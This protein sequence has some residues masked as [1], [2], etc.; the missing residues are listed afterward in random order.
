MT[1]ARVSRKAIR[2][3][4][5]AW[6]LGTAMAI[7]ATMG[8]ASCS[9][10]SHSSA[11][12]G[13]NTGPLDATP[14]DG[15]T[16]DG[17]AGDAM[18]MLP[19]NPD[20][21]ATYVAKVKNLLVGL[22][23][24]PQEVDAVANDPSP[25][26]QLGTLV[27][28]WMGS[29]SPCAP[30]TTT[31]CA[32]LYQTKMLRFFELAF[33][34]TQVIESDFQNQVGSGPG[35]GVSI[36]QN[37]Q[38]LFART[39][40]SFVGSNQ[41]FNTAMTTTKYMMTTSA[42][43]FFALTDAVQDKDSVADVP[44]NDFFTDA[45]PN[46]TVIVESDT[47]IDPA[48]SAT[49]GNKYFMQ[50][51]DPT[52]VVIP[53]PADAGAPVSN[54]KQANRL[55]YSNSSSLRVWYVLN[56]IYFADDGE[57]NGSSKQGGQMQAN[58]YTNWKMVQ[59]NQA[60]TSA[61][62]LTGTTAFYDIASFRNASTASMTLERP[63]VGYFT[64]PAF[65]ANWQTNDS[66]QMRVTA[67]QALIVATG[68]AINPSDPTDA[69]QSPPGLDQDHATQAQCV[70]CHE[71]LD[72][73]R[74]IFS[75]TFSWY[76][77]QQTNYPTTPGAD[78][79]PLLGPDGGPYDWQAEKGR[80]IFEGVSQA[81]SS[82]YDFGTILSTHP[83]LPSAWAQKL[84]YYF[85]SQACVADGSDPVFNA[86]WKAFQSGYSWN[87]LVR[88]VAI[89]PLTTYA[90]KTVTAT[91]NGETVAVSR[92][93]HLC[94]ALDARLGFQDVCRL[95][96]TIYPVIPGAALAIVPGLPS[97][98][99]GRGSAAPILPNQPTLFYR[100][101]TENFCEALAQIVVD[102]KAAPAG[103]KTWQSSDCMAGD[104]SCSTDGGPPSCPPI[105]DFVSLVAGIPSNDP[106]FCPLYEALVQDFVN[107]Q[108]EAGATKTVALQ[109]TFTAACMAPSA[110][111]IGL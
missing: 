6:I 73:T 63:Y 102:Y 95:D 1:L 22:P 19:F 12:G 94:A 87:A 37:Q 96:P 67:N 71:H 8:A 72:P 25:P 101:G 104:G 109:S 105:A 56:G 50:W 21:P 93:D 44:A 54:C 106:R 48:D 49:P 90:T 10:A 92:R 46:Q 76:Y 28:T 64:T 78:G 30:L 84:C 51:Y 111:S 74:S 33:Q 82:I 103:A 57:C 107:N 79:G 29:T 68:A 100:S 110:I 34:Q 15:T 77:G 31:S 36:V 4:R 66:N 23:A 18:A 89:S 85:D 13:P 83:L 40:L 80:F 35:F 61:Q 91:T 24:T 70:F 53:P 65:F 7:A 43:M 41:P 75:S 59:I 2:M 60:P 3:K 58:D 39:M 55:T 32:S 9:S 16:V 97:D 47:V 27:D 98:G 11:T 69:G 86:V 88:A 26:A 99:Y 14:G 62:P 45:F 17:T 52:L 108:S 20:S 5:S 38:E 81:P 42:M